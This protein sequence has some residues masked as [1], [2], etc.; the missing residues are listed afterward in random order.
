MPRI[1]AAVIGLLLASQPP[2]L[3][4]EDVQKKLNIS[5]AAVSSAMRYLEALDVVTYKTPI[6]SRKRL[7]RLEPLKL[8]NYIKRRMVFF[9]RLTYSLQMI[10]QDQSEDTY[11]QEIARL[12]NLCQKLDTAVREIISEW[13]EEQV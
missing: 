3:T 11:K 12:A 4:F 7:I 13:E 6:G 5:K 9:G 8:A 2:E 1:T 10:A